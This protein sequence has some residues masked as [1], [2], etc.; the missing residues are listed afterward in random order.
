MKVIKIIHLTGKH[1][2]YKT[3]LYVCSRD[4]QYIVTG[5][6]VEPHLNSSIKKKKKKKMLHMFTDTSHSYTEAD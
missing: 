3:E 4:M 5:G 6:G 2:K 1:N